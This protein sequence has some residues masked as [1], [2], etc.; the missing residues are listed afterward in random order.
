M[1]KKI[2]I[3]G[4]LMIIVLVAAA[5]VWFGRKQTTDTKPSVSNFDEC[6]A[7]G[8]SVLES[9]P[10]RCVT[11]D[12]KSFTQ[13]IGNELEKRDLIKIE[14][15]R[16]NATIKSPLT[17]KGKARGSWFFEASFPIKIYDGNGKLLGTAAAQAQGEW[18]SSEF[19][20]FIATLEFEKPKTSKGELILE[21]DNPSGLDENDDQLKIPVTF[22]Q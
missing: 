9:Y 15:P 1:N 16:P 7:A 8:Y 17:I 2:L 11:P 14:N 6:A 4:L 22:Q 19:V 13:D 20:D 12:G 3:P 5:F 21:K 18:M 10:A